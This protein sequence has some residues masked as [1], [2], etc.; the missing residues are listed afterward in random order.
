MHTKDLLILMVENENEY[1]QLSSFISIYDSLTSAL[2]Q[3]HQLKFAAFCILFY[4]LLTAAAP[5]QFQLLQKK[6]I[7][8]IIMKS[9]GKN[10]FSKKKIPERRS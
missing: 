5:Y 4:L 8:I 3:R 1:F 6:S 2:A 10:F 9:K 7:I